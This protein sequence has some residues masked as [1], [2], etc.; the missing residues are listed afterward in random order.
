MISGKNIIKNTEIHL[1]KHQTLLTKLAQFNQFN[2]FQSPQ[3][4]IKKKHQEKMFHL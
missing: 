4:E 2:A 1:R 3:N